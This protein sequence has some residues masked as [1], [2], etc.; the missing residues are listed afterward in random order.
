MSS[1]AS[2]K[3]FKVAR[4]NGSRTRLKPGNVEKAL[5]LKHNLKAIGYD[6]ISLS[7]I[8]LIT[9]NAMFGVQEVEV[10]LLALTA[11]SRGKIME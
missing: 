6:S 11:L 8:R 7:D 4:A 9:L 10:T 1:V 3:D 2:E 5:F